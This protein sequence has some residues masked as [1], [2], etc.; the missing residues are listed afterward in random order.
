MGL[1]KYVGSSITPIGKADHDIVY[2]EYDIKVK[3]IHQALRKIF[4]YNR[5]DMEG[6]HDHLAR[7]MDSFLSSDHSRMSHYENTPIQ[8]TDF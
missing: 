4:L 8:Y 3:R 2:V 5:A 6:L 1:S 7:F